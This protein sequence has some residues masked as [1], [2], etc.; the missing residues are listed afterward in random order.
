MFNISI[1]RTFTGLT[2]FCVLRLDTIKGLAIRLVLRTMLLIEVLKFKAGLR[3]VLDLSVMLQVTVS[4]FNFPISS[5]AYQNGIKN[6]I[7]SPTCNK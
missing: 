6:A 1:K 4:L 7:F 5:Y 3:T 2:V